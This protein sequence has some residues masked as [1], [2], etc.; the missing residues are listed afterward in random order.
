MVSPSQTA[1]SRKMVSPSQTA[2]PTKSLRCIPSTLKSGLTITI[3]SGLTITWQTDAIQS[4]WRT[5]I[6]SQNR[7]KYNDTK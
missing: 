3:K 5:S 1:G 4:S 7:T 2:N 6:Y